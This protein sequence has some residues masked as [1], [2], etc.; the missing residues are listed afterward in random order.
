MIFSVGDRITCSDATAST[1]FIVI[2]SPIPTTFCLVIPSILM[3]PEPYSFG[4]L[5]QSFMCVFFMIC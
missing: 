2:L 5:G 3:I 4:E 1:A